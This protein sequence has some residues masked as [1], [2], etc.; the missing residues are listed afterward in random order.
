VIYVGTGQ[1]QPR[2]D[3]ISGDGVFRSDDGG[4]TWTRRGLEAT[5]HIGRI[6]VD[7]RDANTV[8]V[9]ALGHIFG[10]N[11]ERGVFRSTDGGR[12]WSPALFVDENTGV[13]DLA[14]D[15]AQPDVVYASAWQ[16]RNYP[17]LSYFKPNTGPGSGVYRST[18]GG[19]TW[20]RLSGSGWPTENLGRI[21]LAVSPGGRVW[22]LV[23]A[24]SALVE[25]DLKR[26]SARFAG[27]F[28][29]LS[30]GDAA[31]TG[32]AVAESEQLGKDLEK[33]LA[34]WNTVRTAELSA[35]NEQ[36]RSAG[37]PPLKR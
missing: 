12:T 19:R 27:L 32:Q 24:Q 33:S 11:R 17:W 8:L 5:R 22:A 16:F 37:L 23:D 28:G 15:P 20:K 31:P 30:S 14:S 21:G 7:P 6:W 2:Y 1:P 25:N 35:L 4:K 36:L 3:V 13:V 26:I 29:A 9:A 34:Q 10:P 18:D